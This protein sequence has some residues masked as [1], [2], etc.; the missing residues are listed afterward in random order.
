[1]SGPIPSEIIQ[2]LV[3]PNCGALFLAAILSCVRLKSAREAPMLS[4]QNVE[5][6]DVLQTYNY[7]DGYW[8]DKASLKIFVLLLAILDTAHVIST[9]AGAWWYLIPNYGNLASLETVKPALAVA[10]GMT[11]STIQLSAASVISQYLPLKYSIGLLVQCFFA[12]HV[13]RMGRTIVIPAIIVMS[14]LTAFA[15]TA[16]GQRTKLESTIPTIGLTT[17]L[18]WIS[19]TAI[20]T[21]MASDIISTMSLAYYLHIKRTGMKR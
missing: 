20:A 14:A 13:W 8:D 18:Q 1:M 2:S 15:Y 10:V 17:G 21:S 5:F 11:V 6:A 19:D 7:Y 3:V 16:V 12:S 4:K 9:V